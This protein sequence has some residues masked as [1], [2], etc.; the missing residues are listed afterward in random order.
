MNWSDV[1]SFNLFQLVT[2]CWGSVSRKT[3]II[4][5]GSKRDPAF[6]CHIIYETSGIA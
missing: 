1:V 5:A 6:V 2:V 4:N 3:V